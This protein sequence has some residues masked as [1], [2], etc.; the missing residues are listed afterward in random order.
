MSLRS[1]GRTG[2]V[3]PMLWWVLLPKMLLF[4]HQASLHQACPVLI[5]C[6]SRLPV[7]SRQ[8]A[9]LVGMGPGQVQSLSQLRQC[10]WHSVPSPG[11]I[12]PS[13]WQVSH[14]AGFRA[15]NSF[16]YGPGKIPWRVTFWFEGKSC[17]SNCFLCMGTLWGRQDGLCD[18]FNYNVTLFR[19]PWSISLESVL[20]QSV[21]PPGVGEVSGSP[22]ARTG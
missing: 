9:P 16:I 6:F 2:S 11:I 5:L 10:S 22:W 1:I 21:C 19:Y 4:T 14:G 20:A 12:L 17:V 13:T 15:W 8:H 3:V 18:Y 7:A